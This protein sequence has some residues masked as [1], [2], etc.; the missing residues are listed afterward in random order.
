MRRALVLM[1]LVALVAA[2]GN[3]TETVVENIAEQAAER[4]L[5]SETGGDVDID[6]DENSGQGSITIE[7]E[8]GDTSIQFGGGEIPDELS[9][10][11]MDG[12][13]VLTSSV[14]SGDDAFVF[15]TVQYPESMLD[16]LVAFYRDFFDGLDDVVTQ[17]MSGDGVEI[18]SWLADDPSVTV[19]I[20]H[21]GDEGLVT[22]SLSEEG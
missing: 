21:S 15:A 17:E 19:N 18:W 6:I 16:D 3:T 22:I 12:G 20:S 7:S 1:V 11:V 10:P 13:E 9:I 4:S 14:M 2:C 8:E 5:E